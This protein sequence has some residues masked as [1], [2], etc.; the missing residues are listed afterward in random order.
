MVS[1]VSTPTGIFILLAWGS[2]PQISAVPPLLTHSLVGKLD[3]FLLFFFIIIFYYYFIFLSFLLGVELGQP[4]KLHVPRGQ[5]EGTAGQG[6]GAGF[7]FFFFFAAEFWQ[8]NPSGFK[9]PSIC[10]IPE[11]LGSSGLAQKVQRWGK[12]G[13]KEINRGQEIILCSSL[14]FPA[15]CPSFLGIIM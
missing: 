7:I 11:R 14:G 6:F 2:K 10:L 9:E 13:K 1:T 15:L 8:R 12:W 4:S 3:F 5:A